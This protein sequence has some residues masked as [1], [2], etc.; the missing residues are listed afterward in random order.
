LGCIIWTYSGLLLF[1]RK[2][3][4]APSTAL[5]TP[6]STTDETCT[7]SQ[8]TVVAGELMLREHGL[9]PALHRLIDIEYSLALLLLQLP[10]LCLTAIAI[11][12]ESAGPVCDRQPRIGHD[13]RRFMLFKFRSTR[14]DDSISHSATQSGCSRLTRIGGIIRKL[15][16]D[17]LPQLMNVLRG[18]MSLIG[19]LPAPPFV[20][21]ELERDLPFFTDR[22]LVKPGIT[23]WAQINRPWGSTSMDD[24]MLK[25]SCDLYYVAHRS[26]LLDLLILFRTFTLIFRC[27]SFV[28]HSS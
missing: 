11:R 10:L 17:E 26:C 9:R 24:E 22:V 13:W 14:T 15:Q 20:A 12:L 27:Y 19:P 5:D 23:G 4:P 16:I 25:L 21:A 1:A 8:Q 2:L 3:H 7:G 6:L 18:E 28:E